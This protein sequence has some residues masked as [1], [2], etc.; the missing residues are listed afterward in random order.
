MSR[1][2]EMASVDEIL[3]LVDDG[4][5][6]PD[7][8]SRIEATLVEARQ[9]TLDTGAAAKARIA[10]TIDLKIDR[11][12]QIELTI[13]DKIT[14]PKPPKRKGVAWSTTQGGMTAQNPAQTRMEVRDIGHGQRELRSPTLDN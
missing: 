6:Q 14:T 13:E 10:L 12:G 2:K 4:Q 9:M 1:P 11:F 7:L 5:Y 8:M 3:G